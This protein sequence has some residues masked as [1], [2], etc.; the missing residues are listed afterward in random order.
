MR[1]THP[2]RRVLTLLAGTVLTVT[3]VSAAPTVY[4]LENGWVNVKAAIAVG[5]M[6][7]VVMCSPVLVGLVRRSI[8]SARAA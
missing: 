8:N 3:V 5:I 1:S 7:M 4:W 6:V 2:R